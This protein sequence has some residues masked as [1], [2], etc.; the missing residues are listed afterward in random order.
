[1]DPESNKVKDAEVLL[2]ESKKEK[3][4]EILRNSSLVHDIIKKAS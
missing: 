4:L 3:C 1:V 2:L